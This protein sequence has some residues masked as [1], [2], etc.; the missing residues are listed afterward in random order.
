MGFNPQTLTWMSEDK[1]RLILH[2]DIGG[3]PAMFHFY[4]SDFAQVDDDNVPVVLEGIEIGWPQFVIDN[5]LSKHNALPP[6]RKSN[7]GNEA[8]KATVA[9]AAWQC[10][11][12]GS[13]SVYPAKFGKGMQCNRWETYTPGNPIPSWANPQIKSVNGSQRYYCAQREFDK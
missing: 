4:D 9:S 3:Y 13:A 11:E 10:P 2:S 7:S 8:V 12:H 5:V 1:L 6:F